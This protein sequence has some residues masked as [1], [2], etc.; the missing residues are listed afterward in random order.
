VV[1]AFV[2]LEVRFNRIR[3]EKLKH[4][5]KVIP[6]AAACHPKLPQAAVV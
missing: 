2:A 3:E 6:P 1:D 4:E 5:K